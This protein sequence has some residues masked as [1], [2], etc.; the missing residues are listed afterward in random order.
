MAYTQNRNIYRLNMEILIAK[1]L[2]FEDCK[3]FLFQIKMY[4]DVDLK[5]ENLWEENF[6]VS[7]KW[8]YSQVFALIFFDFFV[9]YYLVIKGRNCS[10]TKI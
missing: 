9:F 4:G 10:H 7:I 2:A 6:N 1:K 5:S 8:L 3:L